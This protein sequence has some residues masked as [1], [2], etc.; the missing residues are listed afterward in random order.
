[1]ARPNLQL[2]LAHS[3]GLRY[4]FAATSCAMALGVALLAHRYDFLNME[5]Q[6]GSRKFQTEA[7]KSVSNCTACS[8]P[9]RNT[10]WIS[11]YMI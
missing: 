10:G 2:R 7:A 6:Q 9:M 8:D 4:G 1:M 3:R 11:H 5:L